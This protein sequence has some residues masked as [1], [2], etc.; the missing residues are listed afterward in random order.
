MIICNDYD[1]IASFGALLEARHLGV[2][3]SLEI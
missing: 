1:G 3:A 2:L